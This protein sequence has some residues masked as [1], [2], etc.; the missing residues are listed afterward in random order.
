VTVAYKFLRADATA[1]FSPLRWPRPETGRAAAWIDDEASSFA[2]AAEGVAA[3]RTED[4]PHWIAE[5]LWT[6][7]LAAP[8]VDE[9]VRLRA[10]S[11]RLLARVGAWDADAARGFAVA[12]AERVRAYG[13]SGFAGDADELCVRA[14]DPFAAAAVGPVIAVA[15]ARVAGGDGAVDAERAAERAWFA[16]LLAG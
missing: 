7:E 14:A 1:P 3:Y 15:A 8:V 13:D 12:C 6:V 9:P 5:E 10:P 16:D 11:G 2:P 4:L